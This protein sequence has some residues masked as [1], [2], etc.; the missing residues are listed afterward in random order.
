MAGVKTALDLRD[1]GFDPGPLRSPLRT[2]DET[3]R[4]AL[5]S[6]LSGLGLL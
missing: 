3:D 6:D 1:V 4:D 2:M 5:R